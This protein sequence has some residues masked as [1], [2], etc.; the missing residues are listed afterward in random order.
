L[1]LLN[2]YIC[3][4]LFRIEYLRHMGSIEGAFIGISRYVR[5]HWNDLT[6]IP[7]WNAGTPYPTTYPPLLHLVVA[8]CSWIWGTSTAHVYHAV[9]ALAYCLGPVALFA[10]AFRLSGSKWAAFAAGLIYSS[11][12]ISTL[13]L[14]NVE[15][16]LGSYFYPRRLQTLVF[17]GEGP[18]NSS[19]TLLTFALLFLDIALA[20]RRAIYFFLAAVMFAAT[21]ADNWLGAFATVLFVVPYMLSKF[22]KDWGW[23]PFAWL[24]GITVAAYCLAMP[25]VPPSTI[26]VM[27]ANTRNAGGDFSHAY[28]AAVPQGLAV[29]AALIALKL[30][31][32]RLSVALQ[33]AIVLSFLMTLVTLAEGY[34]QFP[35]VPM[36]LRYHL[37]MELALT[38]LL[39]LMGHALLRNQPKWVGAAAMIA[40]VAL[41]IYPIRMHRRYARNFLLRDIEIARTVEFRTADW[42]NRN[43]NGERVFVTGSVSF[44][45]NAF[46]DTPQLW[47]F[48]MGATDFLVR[49]AQ[50]QLYSSAGSGTH[51]AEYSILWLKAL[52]VHAV[53]ISGP[54]STEIYHPFVNPGKFEGVLDPLWREGD[55]VIYQVGKHA[56]LARVVLRTSLASRTPVNGIDVDPLRPYVAALDNPA[57]PPA[58]IRWA[59]L[60]SATIATNLQPGQVVSVQSA[61]SNGWHATANGRSIPVL[62]DGLGL[63]YLD[64]ET[65]GPCRIEMFYDGGME[66][67]VARV[68]SPLTAIVLLI[69]SIWQFAARGI[70]K[71]S[72]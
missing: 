57:M 29:L 67:R 39:A 45:L 17:Y 47:G 8:F 53:A 38:L 62:R 25:L 34:F 69:L 14:P 31:A 46:T 24:A 16:D 65:A 15:R 64:P 41:S 28:R 36:G 6:W 4:E 18:H 44:W 58:D 68:L 61:W 72:W 13:I 49:V 71:K 33:F 7:L 12:S 21:V 32:R 35:I 22:D 5:E 9:T 52:G 11:F 66:M 42:F 19:M 10:L 1:F 2:V 56:P 50:F 51:D 3:R 30:A 60:H 20:R 70:L 37:E 63:M 23:R 54:K 48:E 40:L 55:D 43:W 59:T 26:A 27:V